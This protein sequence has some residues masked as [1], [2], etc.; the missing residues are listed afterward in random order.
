MDFRWEIY[1]LSTKTWDNPQSLDLANTTLFGIV[2]N[3][4]GNRSMQADLKLF[5]EKPLV[6]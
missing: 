6:F 1:D 2:N 3:A 4:S 5:F